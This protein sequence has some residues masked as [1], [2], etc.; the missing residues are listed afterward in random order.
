MKP[1]QIHGKTFGGPGEP[2]ICMPV[3]GRTREA[4]LEDLAVAVPK[5]PDLIEWRADHFAGVGDIAA[6]IDIASSIK[7][8]A[9]SIPVVFAC[10]KMGEGGGASALNESD[11]LKL[12][13]AACASRCIDMI[14]YELSN[15]P[16][17]LAMLRQASRDNDVAMMM[18]YHD[19]QSTPGETLLATK[20][21]VAEGL[22]AD[23]AK[24][25]VMPNGPEDVL[26]LLGATL[27]ASR[28]C[29]IPLVCMSLGGLGSL[30]R[31]FG[32]VYGSAMTYA[33]GKNRSVPGQ[34]PIDELRSVLASIRQSV[35]GS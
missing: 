2:P 25:V 7:E 11:I 8:K 31:M 19:H 26:T 30:S 1:I 16:A 23:V 28:S 35:Q 33:F 24:V 9:G 5:N 10:R 4:V 12:Y 27:K 15:A 6:V 21:M 32:W 29:A 20:Y 22:G 18:S 13:V 14:D 17:N 34:V 3:A